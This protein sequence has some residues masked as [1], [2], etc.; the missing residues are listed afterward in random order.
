MEESLAQCPEQGCLAE[1]ES[2]V[3]SLSF[4]LGRLTFLLTHQADN[5]S[6][7]IVISFAGSDSFSHG[8]GLEVEEEISTRKSNPW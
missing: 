7:S 2:W 4:N 8:R 6:E 3:F 5:Q 1:M